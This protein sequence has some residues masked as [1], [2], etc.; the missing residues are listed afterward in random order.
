MA[1]YIVSALKAVATP[2]GTVLD[3]ISG[4][5]WMA[6]PSSLLDLLES[7]AHQFVFDDGRHSLVARADT[8]GAA[9][10][11]VV[12]SQGREVAPASLP[13][14]QLEQHRFS[15]IKRRSWWQRLLDP[16]AN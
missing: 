9:R 7:G 6:S 16:D 8:R 12:D 11:V 10:I 13:Q 2:A 15:E 3:R 14:W 5:G 4:P 1:R